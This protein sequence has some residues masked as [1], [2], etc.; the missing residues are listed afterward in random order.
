ML[1]CQVVFIV[2]LVTINLNV[3]CS[4][5]RNEH[6]NNIPRMQL[7][8]GISRNTQSKAYMLLLTESVW[9]FRNNALLDTH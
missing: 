6:D 5:L 9:E 2:A 4:L 8:T 3:K 1:N 7:I